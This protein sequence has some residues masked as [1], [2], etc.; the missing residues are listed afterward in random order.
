MIAPPGSL[1]TAADFVS[2]ARNAEIT[3]LRGCFGGDVKLAR[4]H[5][6]YASGITLDFYPAVQKSL[7]VC[8]CKTALRLSCYVRLSC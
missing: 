4:R 3:V 8:R 6:A 1:I 7:R 5:G 2:T